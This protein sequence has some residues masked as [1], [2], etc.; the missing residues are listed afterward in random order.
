MAFITAKVLYI[1]LFILIIHTIETLAYAVRLSGARVGMIAAALS[2]F[3]LMVI[4]SRMA[5]MLQQPLPEVWWIRLR[6]ERAWFYRRSIPCHHR[7]VNARYPAW[8]YSAADIH[9]PVLA[10]NHSAVEAGRLGAVFDQT[11][12]HP[13]VHQARSSFDAYT[14]ALLFERG[15]VHTYPETLVLHQHGCHSRLYYRRAVCSIRFAACP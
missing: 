8:H 14:E 3:N 6:T 2:L 10:G 1:S 9:R 15:I 4:V 12:S 7:S 11:A 13:A 5:N